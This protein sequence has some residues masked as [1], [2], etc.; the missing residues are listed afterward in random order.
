MDQQADSSPGP[1]NLTLSLEVDV[2][3]DG[4]IGPG[5]ECDD[6]NAVSGDGCNAC[7]V[8]CDT[9]GFGGQDAFPF[10]VAD[11]HHC[12][13][14]AF[15][16]EAS[17]D[18]ARTSCQDWGGDLAALSTEQE[19]GDVVELLAEVGQDVWIGGS[20]LALEGFFQ[21]SNGELWSYSGEQPPWDD[22]VAGPAE[23]AGGTLENC[24]EISSNG[25]LNDAQGGLQQTYLC[26]RP[27]PGK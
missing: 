10:E 26:E 1:F 5:E 2:C 11:S 24:V 18:K 19:I 4:Y 27:P 22:P 6:A 9:D 16:P 13:L 15:A 7:N 21:W 8:V 3:G 17:W 14:Y 20:D 25:E 12:Y 23:P